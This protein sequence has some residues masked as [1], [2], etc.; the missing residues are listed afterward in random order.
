[1]DDMNQMEMIY[2][3][4]LKDRKERIRKAKSSVVEGLVK[5]GFELK[6][7]KERGLYAYEGYKDIY[8]FA[9]NELQMDRTAASKMMKLNDTYSVGGYSEQVREE[10]EEK[11]NGIGKTMLIEMMYLPEEDYE[12]VTP[13][14]RVEDIRELK[15]AEAEQ[16]EPQIEG[17]MN[18]A[19]DFAETVP[20]SE[21]PEKEE[22]TMPQAVRELFRPR[23]MKEYLD[24]FVNMDPAAPSMLWWVEDFRKEHVVLK[25]LPYFFFFFAKEEGVKIKNI[26]TGTIETKSYEELYY[27]A[28]TAFA[29]ETVIG[30]DVWAQAF[31]AEYEEEK[32][33]E[34]E[35]RQ[36]KDEAEKREKQKKSGT[37]GKKRKP[38]GVKEKNEVPAA[39]ETE[40]VTG[41]VEDAADGEEN[42]VCGTAQTAETFNA[43]A[44]QRPDKAWSNEEGIPYL[45]VMEKYYPDIESGRKRFSIRHNDRDYKAGDEYELVFVK[46]NNPELMLTSPHFHIRIT[47]VLNA[48]EGLKEGYVAFGYEVV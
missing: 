26:R 27:L 33:Q 22:M 13:E 31:G 36:R 17:Q 43:E 25:K 34:E 48:F 21:K 41:E 46:D 40:T 7:I 8:D 47:Y 44:A 23:E 14:V 16:E 9:R 1:M 10:L 3:N 24:A 2:L 28:R 15:K 18:M 39:G 30:T 19:E 6:K 45:K 29:K 37:D 35:E 42:T 11:L 20:E 38:A 12:L 32:R 4:E 5:I